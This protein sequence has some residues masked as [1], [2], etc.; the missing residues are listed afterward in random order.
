MNL[1]SAKVLGAGLTTIGLGGAGIGIGI[2]F[3]A[4]INGTSR[5]P[6]VR[7]ELFGLGIIAFALVEALGLFSLMLAFLILYAI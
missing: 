1:I 3:G 5:N 6:S 4:V 2:V 7:K